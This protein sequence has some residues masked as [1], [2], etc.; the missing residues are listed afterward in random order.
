MDSTF[1]LKQLSPLIPALCPSLSKDLCHF[2]TDEFGLLLLSAFH[3]DYKYRYIARDLFARVKSL[4]VL[5]EPDVSIC[6]SLFRPDIAELCKKFPELTDTF[7]GTTSD[8]TTTSAAAAAA[9]DTGTD[10]TACASNCNAC[11]YSPTRM[12]PAREQSLLLHSDD[13]TNCTRRNISGHF[14]SDDEL[15]KLKRTLLI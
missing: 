3:R 10:S 2:T 5:W 14:A 4:A 15:C 12:P 9:P 6:R 1:T 7:T 13:E 8:V 11:A